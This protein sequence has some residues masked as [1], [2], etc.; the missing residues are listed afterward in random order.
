VNAVLAL[1]IAGLFGSGVYAM[2]KRDLIRV[3]IGTSLVSYAVAL[4]VIAS[5]LSRGYAPILPIKDEQA[6]SDP[7]VQ[8]LVLTAIVIGAGTTAVMIGV[9]HRVFESEQSLDQEAASGQAEA[10]DE[11]DE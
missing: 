5:G 11:D 10:E 8:A 9:V 3:V 2:L 7:L 1:A 6:T 4:F